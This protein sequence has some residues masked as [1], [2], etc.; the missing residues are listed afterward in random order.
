MKFYLIPRL[1][2]NFSIQDLRISILGIFRSNRDH[3]QI[4]RLFN[5][6]DIYFTNHARTGLRL[7]LNSFELPPNARIGV[8]TLNC[9]TVFSAIVNAGYQPVF[10][11]IND[12]LTISLDDLKNKS[13]HIDALIVTHIFGMPALIDDIK[14]IIKNKPI[15]EDCAHSFLSRKNGKLTGTFGDAAVFSFGKAKF[16]SIGSGGFVIINNNSIIPKF[17]EF[18]SML[19]GNNVLN[20]IIN[21]TK[22]LVLNILHNR[23]IYRFITFPFIKKMSPHFELNK[24]YNITEKRVLKSNLSLFLNNMN[25]YESLKEKQVK[26]AILLKDHLKEYDNVKT[27]D[28]ANDQEPNFIMLPITTNDKN[29]LVNS[30]FK[31]GLEI[32][33]HFSKSLD[34]AVE[35]G[36]K[37]NDCKN[38]ERL[39]PDLVLLPTYKSIKIK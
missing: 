1:N 30:F 36:Y 32:G 37:K 22:S 39:I 18:F 28:V 19:E 6:K 8:Q 26:N 38:A 9:H 20:E 35:L 25:K 7:L 13:D 4:A 3:T 23:L 21:L 12:S 16:P 15:V 34:W 24:K 31:K 11:D 17:K 10:I 14:D 29:K 27:I 5:S 33:T 2:Y